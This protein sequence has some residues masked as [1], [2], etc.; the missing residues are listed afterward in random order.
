MTT[1]RIPDMT[2]GHCASTIARAVASVAKDARL[3][4]NIPEKLVRI[5]G[6]TAEAELA[7]AIADAGYTV[8]AVPDS[9]APAQKRAGGCCCGTRKSAPVDVRQAGGEPGSSCCG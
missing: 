5:S 9:P 7:E 3:D 1:F 2:C 4:F 8:E 6:D